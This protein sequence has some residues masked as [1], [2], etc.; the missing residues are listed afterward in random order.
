M[1]SAYAARIGV[2]LL[3]MK[4][5]IKEIFMIGITSVHKYLCSEKSNVSHSLR[6][7]TCTFFRL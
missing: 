7:M 5:M 4:I 3:Y 1:E 6:K 2:I